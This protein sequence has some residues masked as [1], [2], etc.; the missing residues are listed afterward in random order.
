MV[1]VTKLV[2]SRPI[3]VFCVLAFLVVVFGCITISE[4]RTTTDNVAK[5]VASFTKDLRTS[6]VSEIENIGKF[7]YPKTNLSTIGLARVIDSYLTNNDI[8]FAE[9]QTQIA[10]LLF[11]AYSTIPQ[12]SQ[13]SYIS[14]D[15]LFFSYIAESNTSVAVFANSSSNSSG[16]DYTWYTQNID[17]LTGRLNGNATKSQPL[18]LTHTDWFQA[19]QSNN[20]TTTFLGTSLGEK[21]NE[22]LIQSVVSL[23]NK[24]G[25]VSLGFPVKTLTDVLNSLN[26]HGEELYM[27]TKDGTVLVREGSLN[28]SFFISNG[29]IC[30]GRDSKS[31]WSQCISENCSTIGYKVEIKRSTYQA[32][33]SVLEVSGV[34]LRYTLMFPNEGGATRIKHQADKAMYQLIVVVIFLGLGWPVWFVWFMMQ[35]TRREMRMRA[36]LIN[37][38][39]ATQQA[40]RKSMNKSQAFA[41]ASHDI[42]GAL[43]AMK[44]LIDICRDEV[45]PGS[46]IDTTLKQVNA[47]SKDLVVLLN[48]V[49]DM[50]KI[51]SGKMQLV[52]EDFNLSKLLED[53]TDF[54]HPVAMKK[55]VDVV[56]DSHDGSI[57]KFSNVRGDSGK[58][59][60]ILNNLVSNA[61][62]FTVDG[63]ILIRAWAQRPGSKSSVILASDPQ[64]VSKFLKSMLCK[65]K[66]QSSNYEAEISNSIRNNANTMEFVFEVDDTGKGIPMEM[67]KSVFENYVQV[68]ETA[69]GQ[70]GTGL[71]LGIVQSLVRL[72]GGE[73]RITDKAMGEKGTCFQFNVLLTTL[74]SP[75]VS[76][77]KVRPDIQAGGDYISTPD[78][79]LTINTSLGGSMN[80]RNLS[81]R[82]NNCLSSSP[83]QECSRV[84]LLLKNEERRRVT[85]KYIKNLGIKVTMVEKWEHLSYAL[86]RLFGFS[87]Q[88]SMGRAESSLSCPSSRE[89]PLIGMDGIDSRS[90]LPKRRS[91]SFSAVVL[92]V[93]DAKTGPLLE[94]YDIVKQFRKGLPHGITCKV[95]WLNE[96]STRVSERG[97]ISC[98]R[99]LHGSRLMEVLKML[100]EFGGTVLKETPTELQRESLLRHSFVAERSPKH[101]FQEEGPC[102]MFNK[103]LGKTIMA[104]TASESET[105]IKSVSSG[106]KPI[107]NAEDEEGTSKPSDD[108]FLRGKRVLVVDDNFLT[109]KVATGKLKKMGV[110]E[111]LQCD[112]GK[113]A[114][115]LVTEGLTQKEEQCSVNK[116]PFDY[117]F[118]DCQM[119]EMDGYEATRE[120]RK[121]E[122]SY[123]VRIPVIAVSGHDPGS[124][125]ARETVQAGMDA[126]LDKSLNQLANVI[127]E[128]ES[129]TTTLH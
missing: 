78:L 6:I 76:D 87:P 75:P 20:Y 4:W 51:E 103:K 1:K 99:P 64:G 12:V 55:G 23:Y 67:R 88:S 109:R 58:L 72:M 10:P 39:E 114:L 30:F 123:G 115:R 16:G 63:H 127:R 100:P 113:E 21:D 65:N 71:G 45:K 38:M 57:F 116:L 59:K 124:R 126:F 32:F 19:A 40:E 54:Y 83:K 91:T 31:V 48:S 82:F 28:A 3:V 52:E 2:A 98:S 110:S 118:M 24:K 119:P 11:E 73:I 74:E 8:G 53:V 5:D 61:V 128:I 26:L 105:R 35:A 50:S 80:I 36:M 84:V 101:K 85:E 117:I 17:Q 44:G 86:E 79:G 33:C 69:Q 93:I 95:V 107:G 106:R 122:K 37:Q 9:I 15:G 56:L 89:L 49:L 97:D 111:V 43:A 108:E 22:T 102:S 13:V 77:M 41:N 47:C 62:K 92:L 120:I 14:R 68:R 25:L 60:Q 125:E 27:W 34:P 18:D 29:S 104:P 112:S 90:Q 94:L 121:V 66:D 7:T 70:Q 129:K 81:P 42:R 96:S 46:D